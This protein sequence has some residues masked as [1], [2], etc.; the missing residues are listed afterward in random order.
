MPRALLFYSDRQFIKVFCSFPSRLGLPLLGFGGRGF[1]SE[2]HIRAPIPG[3]LNRD[4]PLLKGHR[5]CS[6]ARK[7]L[8]TALAVPIAD[9]LN[10]LFRKLR[11]VASVS[12]SAN[13]AK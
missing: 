3:W 4:D 8:I 7:L 13:L 11:F 10:K 12:R 6:S 1:I 5:L 9:S 2:L